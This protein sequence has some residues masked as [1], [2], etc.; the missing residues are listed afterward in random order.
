[1]LCVNGI[2]F[3]RAGDHHVN[4]ELLRTIP[5]NPK[6]KL[7]YYERYPER[8]KGPMPPAPAEPVSS[9]WC[10]GI[11]EEELRRSPSG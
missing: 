5:P 10:M 4:P 1:M 2:P 6:R 7:S 11:I 8:L 3:L 9:S